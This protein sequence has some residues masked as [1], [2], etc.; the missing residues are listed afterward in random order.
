MKPVKWLA[1][2]LAAIPLVIVTI[3]AQQAAID[4][5]VDIST[6]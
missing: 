3:H 2:A 1:A 4:L 5:P 6:T